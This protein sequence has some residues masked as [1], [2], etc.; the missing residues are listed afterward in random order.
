[1]NYKSRKRLSKKLSTTKF[2]IT[3]SKRSSLPSLPLAFIILVILVSHLN[4]L[5]LV[6][7]ELLTSHPY[8]HPH[9]FTLASPSL[10]V[11]PSSSSSSSSSSPSI[12]ESRFY[13]SKLSSP[14]SSSA[15]SFSSNEQDSS[16]ASLFEDE[17]YRRIDAIYHKSI[18]E[19]LPSYPHSHARDHHALREAN[20]DTNNKLAGTESK[21][22]RKKKRSHKHLQICRREFLKPI[23]KREK[24]ADLVFTGTIERIK[25]NPSLK[26]ANGWYRANVRVKQVIKGN[27]KLEGTKVIVEGFGSK[28]ICE[29]DGKV[30]DTR[31]FLVNEGIN[32]RLRLNSS[33]IKINLENLKKIVQA[34]KCKYCA[35]GYISFIIMPTIFLYKKSGWLGFTDKKLDQFLENKRCKRQDT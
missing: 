9:P 19:H 6:D 18:D 10:S 26:L 14:I 33:L 34:A 21:R 8:H 16:L 24:E 28:K 12:I 11:N 20:D 35:P 31:I 25:R 7:C 4:L 32:G 23:E 15:S 27:A 13:R 5:S 3:A 30:K 2:S 29:S 1:M 17:E 22:A